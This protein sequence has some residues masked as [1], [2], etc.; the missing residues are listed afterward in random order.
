MKV[1]N[2]RSADCP[3]LTFCLLLLLTKL[4]FLSKFTIWCLDLVIA[5]RCLSP[6]QHTNQPGAWFKDQ[7][8]LG[9]KCGGKGVAL[10]VKMWLFAW[11]WMLATGMGIICMET[12]SSGRMS[13][14]VFPKSHSRA[15][16]WLSQGQLLILL[17]SP[18]HIWQWQNG[19][20]KKQEGPTQRTHPSPPCAPLC[21]LP[22]DRKQKTVF[23]SI[24]DC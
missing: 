4:H 2:L 13:Q 18:G 8:T 21:K 1:F 23:P 10:W 11:Q 22:K 7:R 17:S 15:A 24:T 19:W 12:R 3:L 6:L 16:V 14:N 5:R 9:G 20:N